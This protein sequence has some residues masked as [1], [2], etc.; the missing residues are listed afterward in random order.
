MIRVEQTVQLNF[1]SFRFGDMTIE[2]EPLR[3]AALVFK[4]NEMR[5]LFLFDPHEIIKV[6]EEQEGVH[7][8][9]FFLTW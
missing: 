9:A 2:N 7:Y 3:H 4:N 1:Q 6:M 5:K 8:L